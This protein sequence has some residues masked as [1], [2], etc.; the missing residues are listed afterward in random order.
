MSNPGGCPP[1]V[2]LEDSR[3]SQPDIVKYDKEGNET[4]R[5]P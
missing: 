5:T 2:M 4:S 3:T 1:H